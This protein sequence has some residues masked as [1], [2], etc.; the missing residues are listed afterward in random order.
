M[1]LPKRSLFREQAI[2]YHIGN[3]H[4]DVLP[5][6]VSPPVFSFLWVLVALC[7]ASGW[8]ASTIHLPILT[9]GVGMVL[10]NSPSGE[11]PVVLFVTAAQHYALHAGESARLQ[12]GT[13]GPVLPGSVTQ[14]ASTI[15][16]PQAARLQ[17][18]LDGPIALLVTQPS[19]AL[20]VMLP[21]GALAASYQG[22]VA[23]AQ[24]Q[25]GE[26]SLLSFSVS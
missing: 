12:I 7:L 19:V 22:S 3:R 14:V 1:S 11:T 5:R 15:L 24:I 23:Q 2:Q 17:Y 4:K 6:F 18:G 13:G 20:T 8:I 25:I 26:Q 9:P 10:T 21:A 16:S